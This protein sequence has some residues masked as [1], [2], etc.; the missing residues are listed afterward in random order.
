MSLFRVKKPINLPLTTEEEVEKQVKFVKFETNQM[1]P[2]SGS[3]APDFEDALINSLA[4]KQDC[5]CKN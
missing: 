4:E 5:N 3:S 2:E 1:Q